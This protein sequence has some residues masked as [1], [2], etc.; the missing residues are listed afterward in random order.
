MIIYES[1]VLG[2]KDE[3]SLGVKNGYISISN[4]ASFLG[5]IQIS[6]MDIHCL[7]VIN[8]QN[9]NIDLDRWFKVIRQH[10]NLKY[11]YATAAVLRNTLAYDVYI[12]DEDVLNFSFDVTHTID[13]NKAEVLIEKFKEDIKTVRSPVIKESLYH[14]NNNWKIIDGKLVGVEEGIELIFSQE[15]KKDIFKAVE[16]HVNKHLEKAEKSIND[17]FNKK[18]F[19]LKL[20]KSINQEKIF[21]AFK[22]EVELINNKE[23]LDY[24]RI[25]T[26]NILE[27]LSG[28]KVKIW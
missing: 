19:W 23:K 10:Q 22:K 8:D 18:G 7:N 2:D 5:S 28:M 3:I 6:W 13:I 12:D 15:L 14:E 1:C 11:A 26:V 4:I 27:E 9:I 24:A 16:E 17:E 21:N 25:E 20:S